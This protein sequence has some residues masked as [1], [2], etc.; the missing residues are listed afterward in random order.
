MQ[1]YAY[2][3]TRLEAV[4]YRTALEMRTVDG[5]PHYLAAEFNIQ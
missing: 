5:G 4:L 1:K 3:G 2:Y